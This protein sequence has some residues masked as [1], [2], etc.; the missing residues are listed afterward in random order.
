MD[1]VLSYFEDY[2]AP[3]KRA[4]YLYHSAGWIARHLYS[5]LS[6][7]GRVR[8]IDAEER[9]QN[10]EAD[11]FI[12]HFWNFAEQC[13]GNHFKHKV[14][15]YSIANPDWSY[16]LLSG[17]AQKYSVPF[18]GWDFPPQSFDNQETLESADLILLIGNNTIASTFPKNVQ[19]KIHTLN[20]SVDREHFDTDLQRKQAGR[21]CY[22]ATQCDLR[23]GFMDVLRTF[24]QIDSNNIQLDIIGAIKPAWEQLYT[25]YNTGNMLLHGWLNS[26]SKAYVNLLNKARFA[27]IPTYSEG[28]MG[29]LLETI[30]CGCIPITTL[31]SGIDERLLSHCLLIEPFNIAQQKQTVEETARWSDDFWLEKIST[32][33]KLAE[34]Y[35]SEKHFRNNI[36]LFLKS[37]TTIESQTQLE[38]AS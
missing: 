8:Y 1:I 33:I 19:H 4:K 36:E 24:S 38:L 15:V 30:F 18:P 26:S 25:R 2:F 5:I 34:Q 9:P 17:L 10:I 3:N 16:E 23:K 37:L 20:Y 12:G 11:I 14:A 35:Q 22:V 13:K 32:L 7:Y 21:Y 28:Q 27:Y 29:T 6:E 31:M